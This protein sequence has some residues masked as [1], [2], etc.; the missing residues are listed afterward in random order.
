M[1]DSITYVTGLW[2]LD[3]GRAPKDFRRDFKEHYLTQF[4]ELLKL[5]I[6]LVVYCNEE[7]E[8]F[9]W[10]HRQDHNT[11]VIRRKAGYFKHNF[12]FYK[13]VQ[14]IRTNIDWRAQAGWLENSPQA[15]LPLYNPMVFC[16]FFM[17]HDVSIINPFNTENFFWLDGGLNSTVHLQGYINKETNIKLSNITEKLLF[18]A[19]PYDGKYEV[20]GFPKEK[21][22]EYAG[23]DTT[24]VC[25][26]GFFGGKGDAI[27]KLNN[28]YYDLLRDTLPNGLMGTEE[29]IF[30]IMAYTHGHLIDRVMIEPNGLIYKF[31]EDLKEKKINVVKPKVYKVTKKNVYA[32]LNELKIYVLT[33]N[34]PAQLNLLLSNWE[35][36]VPE[37]LKIKE[38]TLINNSNVKD[39]DKEYL[40]IAKKY[41]FYYKSFN[42]IGICGGRQWAAEDFQ[43]SN[44]N[45]TIFFED[46]MLFHEENRVCS[47]GFSTKHDNFL[48]KAIKIIK[49]EELDFL[50]ISF[51]EFFGNNTQQ[52]SYTNVPKHV[53]EKYFEDLQL[54]FPRDYDKLPPININYINN[55]DG[56]SYS[57][58][59]YYYCNWPLILTKEGNKKV[60]IDTKWAHP[61]EQTWMSH[62]FQLQKKNKLKTGSLLLSPINHT[63]KFFYKAE[64]RREN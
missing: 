30:T 47:C 8:K 10:E 5:D 60:F 21:M 50:K 45:F 29:S 18:L 36:T 34:S 57:C 39:F 46:D 48:E 62:C 17:L 27:K 59:E 32:D 53:K 11:V 20:H 16:K 51:T 1:D 58:G 4:K 61:Y 55:V 54:T 25:R 12:D 40:E 49:F 26:A 41:G 3:R 35:K 9:V 52:W 44:Q 64:V 43:K 38:K 24:F 22:N 6:N 31:F 19:F 23:E 14:E 42:N 63:R 33:F 2:D 56:L 15:N 7:V 28:I 37:L 13:Q